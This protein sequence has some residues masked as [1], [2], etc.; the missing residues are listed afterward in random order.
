MRGGARVN[1]GPPPDPNALRR[2]R[3]TD[4]DGWKSLPASGRDGRLPKWPLLPDL[5]RR[6]ELH[7]ATVLLEQLQDELREA[8]A[9][10]VAQLERRIDK[11]L[12]QQTI[13]EFQLADQTKLERAMWREIWKTPQATVWEDQ[14]W[15]RD[16]AQF[17]R[18]KV[19][20]ELGSLEDAKE[21]RQWSDRLGL[22][23]AAMQ[24][25]RWRITSV[26]TKPAARP[27][28]GRRSSRDRLRVVADG[29]TS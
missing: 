26:E 8:P 12:R 3:P 10:K 24:R 4:K 18:H 25:N 27:T 28:S 9:G 21:A 6:A 13:L 7:A 17:V 19:L 1:S 11:V 16:V 29:E 20:G 5:Q 23:P 14:G 15:F 2:D 22:N